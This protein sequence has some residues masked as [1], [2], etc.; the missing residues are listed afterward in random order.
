MI[1]LTWAFLGGRRSSHY[2]DLCMYQNQ[3]FYHFESSYKSD[4][5]FSAMSRTKYSKWSYSKKLLDCFWAFILKNTVGENVSMC[6][7]SRNV[8][9]LSLNK[10][11]KLLEFFVRSEG[12]YI[13]QSFN[14][15][16]YRTC[17]LGMPHFN[18]YFH[19]QM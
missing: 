9:V 12:R 11:Y 4:M 1:R 10:C 15:T 8:P 6:K 17:R 13:S 2:T 5:I 16:C 14:V 18:A 3:F 19:H 7:V